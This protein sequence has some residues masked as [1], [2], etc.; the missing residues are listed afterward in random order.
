M[1]TGTLTLASVAENSAPVRALIADG[2]F[3]HLQHVLAYHFFDQTKIRFTSQLIDGIF[4]VLQKLLKFFND[5]V[6][7]TLFLASLPGVL[8]VIFVLYLKDSESVTGS[9]VSFL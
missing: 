2:F 9:A 3:F 6:V 8:P 1:A 4:K 5:I 7:L